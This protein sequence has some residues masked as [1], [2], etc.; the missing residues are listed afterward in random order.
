MDTKIFID[1]RWF[2]VEDRFEITRVFNSVHYKD[3]KTEEG[4]WCFSPETSRTIKIP[5]RLDAL[6]ASTRSEQVSVTTGIYYACEG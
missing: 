5:A 3:R 1:G 2:Y 4:D 6:C